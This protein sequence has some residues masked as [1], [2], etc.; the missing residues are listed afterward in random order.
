MNT[1]LLFFA[2][3]VA[4][5]LLAIVFQ[6]ILRSPIL[7]ATMTFAIYLI[8]TFSAFD[9]TFLIYAIVYTIL[10]LISAYI[11]ELFFER[12]KLFNSNNNSNELGI[13]DNNNTNSGNC[14]CNCQSDVVTANLFN[15]R[16]GNRSSWCCYRRN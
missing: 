5:I 8:V 1:L 2:L 12:C 16:T 15:N 9:S 11:A 6:K 3:P 13:N 10:A 14:N 4:T 7:V